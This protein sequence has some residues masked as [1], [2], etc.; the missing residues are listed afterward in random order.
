M[1]FKPNS[2][3]VVVDNLVCVGSHGISVGSL[4]QCALRI[5][6]QRIEL[7]VL[8]YLD[9]PRGIRHRARRP[10]FERPHD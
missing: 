4:G 8:L 1:S 7:I 6:I 10:G 9:R 3:R 5:L 2:T